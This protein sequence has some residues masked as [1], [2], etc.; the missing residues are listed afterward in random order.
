[1][2]ENDFDSL[3]EQVTSGARVSAA[4]WR[5][6]LVELDEEERRRLALMAR[7]TAQSRFGKGVY[8]RA[9][10]EISSYCRNNCYYCGLR[11]SNSMAQ[12]YRLSKEEILDCCSEAAALGFDTF[13]LQGGE[14]PQQSDGWLADVVAAIRARYPEKAITLSVGERT[15]AGYSMLRNA[16]ADRYLLRHETANEKHY[17][18]LHPASMSAMNRRRCLVDLKAL[19]YQVGSG[20]MIGSPGQTVECLVDDMRLLDLFKPHMIG[21]GP[22]IPA[23]GTPFA[24]EPHGSVEE[25]LHLISL[26]RLRFPKALIPATTALATLCDDGTQR[27]L[28]AG[29][30]VVMPNFTPLSCRRKYTIYNNKKHDGS[31]SAQGLLTL[32]NKLEEIGYHIDFS[33]GDYPYKLCTT[34][35]R[36]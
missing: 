20:M 6:L 24:T 11:C 10:I 2:K 19:G 36:K 3:L 29:A 23:S 22:F 35:N 17:S 21:I 18:C 26:L 27:A 31:E 1:M 32:S 30:N 34:R 15:I 14:D 8:V 33:R 9:L 5:T 25:T 28:L 13:V 16:G 7:Q 4:M 12:R